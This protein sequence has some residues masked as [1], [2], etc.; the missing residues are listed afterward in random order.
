MLSVALCAICF[1]SCIVTKTETAKVRD[2]AGVVVHIPTIADLDVPAN[3][4]SETFNVKISKNWRGLP[5]I[6]ETVKS[7]AT[8]QLLKKYDADVL[9]EPRYSIEN[10][11]GLYK[12]KFNVVVSGYPA[13]YKNFRPM[14]D[15]DAIFLNPMPPYIFPEKKTGTLILK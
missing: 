3:R 10:A 13:K 9:I 2:V 12:F 15:K 6:T 5:I 8:A 1:S 7:F 11:V 4:V 14:A